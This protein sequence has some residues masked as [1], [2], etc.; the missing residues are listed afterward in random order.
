MHRIGLYYIRPIVLYAQLKR[1]DLT[2]ILQ[3][4]K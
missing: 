4:I 1:P 2:D 3:E